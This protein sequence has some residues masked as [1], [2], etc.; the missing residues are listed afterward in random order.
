VLRP[1][2]HVFGHIHEARG[3]Y[4]HLWSSAASLG[5]QNAS[6]TGIEGVDIAAQNAEVDDSDA[7]IGEETVPAGAQTIFVNASN[8]PAGPNECRNGQSVGMGGLGVQPVV[9]DLLE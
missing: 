1:R 9:V 8:W 5:A 7:E 6:Q 2:L 3:A 4:V